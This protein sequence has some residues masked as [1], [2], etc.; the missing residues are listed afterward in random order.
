MNK[1]G[2]TN[3]NNVYNSNNKIINILHIAQKIKQK[4]NQ[5][6]GQDFKKDH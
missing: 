4:S 6:N 1:Y 5:V 2:A 3:Y